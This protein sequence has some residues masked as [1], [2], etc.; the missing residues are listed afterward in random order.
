M[1]RMTTLKVHERRITSLEGCVT[2]VKEILT[3]HSESIYRL[4]RDNIANR[5]G[6]SMILERLDLPL[7]TEEQ[8]D[9]VLDAR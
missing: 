6:I 2:D 3:S 9:E 7:I 8:I 1:K 4:E 5:L